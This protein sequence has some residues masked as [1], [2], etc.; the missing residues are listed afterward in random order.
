MYID[1]SNQTASL[2]V[3]LMTNTCPLYQGQQ[4]HFV[5][6]VIHNRLSIHRTSILFHVRKNSYIM[7]TF[8]DYSLS[9]M[10]MAVAF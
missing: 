10:F 7:H 1:M 5:L 4:C 8:Q 3:L 2:L 9:Y 6:S